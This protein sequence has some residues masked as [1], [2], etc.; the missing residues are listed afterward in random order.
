MCCSTVHNGQPQTSKELVDEAFGNEGWC[1]C[2]GTIAPER[3]PE[4]G[5]ECCGYATKND[6]LCDRCREFCQPKSEPPS[7][8]MENLK[9]ELHPEL[10]ALVSVGMGRP[11]AVI[12]LSPESKAEL[13]RLYKASGHSAPAV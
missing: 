9:G 1:V 11:V 4:A 5:Q 7:L 13:N 2:V 3:K 6:G 12:L 10:S 8:V